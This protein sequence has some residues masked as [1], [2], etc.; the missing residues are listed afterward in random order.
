MNEVANA[1]G[2]QNGLTAEVRRRSRHVA[3]KHLPF[4]GEMAC[5]HRSLRTAIIITTTVVSRICDR[6]VRP[7]HAIHRYGRGARID[8]ES[9]FLRVRP[10]LRDDVRVEISETAIQWFGHLTTRL[11][12]LRYDC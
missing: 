2:E 5:A 12:L 11:C 9:D 3:C 10:L 6:V 7:A 8:S 1:K 4:F